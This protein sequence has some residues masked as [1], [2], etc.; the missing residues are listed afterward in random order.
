[1]RPA[2]AGRARTPPSRSGKSAPP[3]CRRRPR[4]A[5]RLAPGRSTGGRRIAMPCRAS[6]STAV[7]WTT[8]SARRGGAG[9][10]RSP[11][12][13]RGWIPPSP[14]QGGPRTALHGAA[15]GWCERGPRRDRARGRQALSRART[16]RA[17]GAPRPGSPGTAGD[18]LWPA[19]QGGPR[20]RVPPGDRRS[21]HAPVCGAAA[22]QR[23]RLLG[24]GG[25]L[26]AGG[27]GAGVRDRRQPEHASGDRRVAVRA[28]PPRWEFVF[29]PQDAADRK[30]I[31][32]WWKRRRSRA[33]KGRRFATWEQLWRAVPEATADGH[34]HRHPWVWGRRRR[35]RPRRR[36]GIALPKAA[37][38]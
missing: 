19:R 14:T 1:M 38:S 22:R 8:C 27:R 18:G 9:A 21:V 36:P 20:W 3:R 5:R 2:P 4:A 31:E 25:R 32:P 13:A 26:A 11:G 23:G 17:A 29:Q 24:V 6:R 7:G 15:G 34:A 35:Q 16:A 33:R 12:S 30:R 28:G 10:P 37:S